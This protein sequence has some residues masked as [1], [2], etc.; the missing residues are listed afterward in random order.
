MLFCL[1][2]ILLPLLCLSVVAVGD[3]VSF[4][5]YHLRAYLP[6][7]LM[8]VMFCFQ[9]L[10]VLLTEIS[11]FFLQISDT[12]FKT[13][14]LFKTL[15]KIP[16]K[17]WVWSFFFFITIT[18]YFF[19]I[20]C[21]KRIHINLVVWVLFKDNK[22]LHYLHFIYLLVAKFLGCITRRHLSFSSLNWVVC[23][24]S[25]SQ[26]IITLFGVFILSLIHFITVIKYHGRKL[27][28][29]GKG[30]FQITVSHH[31]ITLSNQGRNSNMSG[32]CR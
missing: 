18:F 13:R 7:F 1:L 20:L 19:S 29:D 31:G 16:W 12:D 9:A 10:A 11:I 21:L 4:F 26:C 28:G 25:Y 8:C 23:S 17:F 14:K 30:L 6:F 24:L 15:Y 3:N 22:I 2:S 27:L 32:T 5:S